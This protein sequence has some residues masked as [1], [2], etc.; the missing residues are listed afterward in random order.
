MIT[1][2]M[3]IIAI[4]SPK[5]PVKNTDRQIYIERDIE[6]YI[7]TYTYTYKYIHIVI[8]IYIHR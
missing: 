5:L 2:I 4:V 8:Y 7:H 6:R 1:L 3:V